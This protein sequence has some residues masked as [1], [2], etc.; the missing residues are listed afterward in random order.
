[1]CSLLFWL[2]CSGPYLP[3]CCA[4]ELQSAVLAAIEW[5]Y[6]E[7]MTSSIPPSSKRMLKSAQEPRGGFSFENCQRN[8]S[9]ER[10]LPGLRVP[11]ARKTGTTIAGLVF[12]LLWGWSSRR[13]RNDYTDGCIQHGAT[14]NVHWTRAS[15]G[16]GHS[17]PTPD[18]IPVPGTRGRIADRGRSRLDRTTTLW[19]APPRFLQPTALYCSGLRAGRCP[20]GAGGPVPAKHD[21][22]GCTGAAGG[23]YYRRNPG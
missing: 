23:S 22:G 21:A 16:H 17:P 12:R 3:L 2:S 9:L 4:W 7:R 15:R 11:H 14:R 1:M 5:M 20:G 6:R 10:V 8:A 13:R 19:R 18:A